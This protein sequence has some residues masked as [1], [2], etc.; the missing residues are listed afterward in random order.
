MEKC[1]LVGWNRLWMASAI[2]VLLFS[3]PA[4]VQI[5]GGWVDPPSDLS[6]PQARFSEVKPLANVETDPLKSVS[7]SVPEGAA[8]LTDESKPSSEAVQSIP[9]DPSADFSSLQQTMRNWKLPP[10][11]VAMNEA[12][13][14]TRESASPPPSTI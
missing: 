13:E 8:R 14:P 6:A 7:I 12:A 10:P 1:M 5:K 2:P 9:E 4:L 3:S 11:T